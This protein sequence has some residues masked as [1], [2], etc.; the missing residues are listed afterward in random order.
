MTTKKYSL[1]L[2]GLV[3]ALA[4]ISIQAADVIAKWKWLANSYWY[5]PTNNLTAYKFNPNANSLSVV[6]DQT[7]F[8]I[9]NYANGNFW[10][11]VVAQLGANTPSC[12]SIVGSV[13]PEGK[14][15]I[16]FTPNPYSTG[17]SVIIGLGQMVM[18]SGKWTMVNQMS[19]GPP[20]LQIGHWAYMLQTKPGQASWLSLPGVSTP[21]E[22][23]LAQCPNGPSLAP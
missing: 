18:K 5:V 1:T 12:Q 6:S 11:K 23:F 16:T 19:S 8:Q 2:I 15:Y 10:G 4:N 22:T 20:S 7:V 17:D 3:L 21:V 13:T 14:V 9:T